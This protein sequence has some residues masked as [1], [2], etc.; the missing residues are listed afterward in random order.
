MFLRT[1]SSS[2]KEVKAP[3]TFDVELGIALHAIQGNGAS[4]V[5]EGD[6]SWCFS[7][8]RGN[9][10][11]FTSHDGEG[12][13]KL[14]LVQKR[15]DSSLVA[16]DT[17]GCSSRLGRAIGMPLEMRRETQCPFSLSTRILG[18]LSIFKR[19]Q[20]SSPF[21]A[22]NSTF[23]SSCQKGVRPP[24]LKSRG[25]STLSMVSSGYSDIPSSWEIKDEPAF[26]SLPR[27]PALF[28]VKASRC[29]FHLRQQTQGPSHIPMAE[30]ILLF[31]CMWKVGNPL[32]LKQGIS[33]H[34]EMNEGTRR[35]SRVAVLNMMFH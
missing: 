2:I 3:I 11:I 29:P 13:S 35:F 20:T 19:I 30:R 14:V 22:L 4:S 17:S 31:R 33:S 27:N 9:L 8:C 7:S 25:T 15:H 32:E 21:E 34:L 6:V 12:P 24:V 26:K 16:R 23:L 1:L 10:G 5:S 28:R 18:F